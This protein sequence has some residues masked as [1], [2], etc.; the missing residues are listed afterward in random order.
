[1]CWDFIFMLTRCTLD[2]RSV[3]L[4]KEEQEIETLVGTAVLNLQKPDAALLKQLREAA[5]ATFKKES[6]HQHPALGAWVGRDSA[7]GCLART[8]LSVADFGFDSSVH[9]RRLGRTQ[10]ALNFTLNV[11]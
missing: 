2:W 8:A 11:C 7:G 5:E 3:E 1:V 9:R 4:N 6:S 10:E